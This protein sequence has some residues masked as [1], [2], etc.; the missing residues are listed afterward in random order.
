V[1]QNVLWQHVT[2]FTEVGLVYNSPFRRKAFPDGGGNFNRILSRV[3]HLKKW[4]R[5]SDSKIKCD[6][7]A[8]K[9]ARSQPRWEFV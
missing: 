4:R 6:R 2:K 9:L 8:W 7:L 1:L 5:F 3:S